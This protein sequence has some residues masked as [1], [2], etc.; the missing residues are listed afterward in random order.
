VWP[1]AAEIIKHTYTGWPAREI[2][3][4]GKEAAWQN[5]QGVGH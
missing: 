5:A 1:R 4:I 3:V 2:T